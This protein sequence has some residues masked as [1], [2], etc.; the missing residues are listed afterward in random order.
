MLTSAQVHRWFSTETLF[1]H[2]LSVTEENAA[3][4]TNLGLVAIQKDDY[5]GA[6]RWLGAALRIDPG[7]VDAL[8]NMG[9]MYAKQ[10]N[11]AAAIDQYSKIVSIVPRNVKALGNMARAFTNLGNHVQ[12]EIFLRRV[13][14]LEPASPDYRIS[15]AQTQQMLGKTQEALENYEAVPRLRPGERGAVNNI[16]WIRAAHPDPQFRDG[17][18]AVELLRALSAAPDC[19][20][21]LLDTLG[22]AYAEAGQFEEALS[23]AQAAIE[24]AR[25]EK[26]PAESIKDMERRATLYKRAN[27]IEIHSFWAWADKRLV[28]E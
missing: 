19:D 3:A 22:A 27:R 21:N 17:A 13:V 11:Y 20:S 7:F 23:T 12:A 4:L 2:T 8:G 5:E 28:K 10:K 6:R 15:L 18:K 1:T 14:E 9:A 25:A 16:A 24:K 26:A